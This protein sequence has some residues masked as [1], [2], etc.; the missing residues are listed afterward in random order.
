[1]VVCK[2]YA[3]YLSL[4]HLPVTTTPR[5]E[6]THFQNDSIRGVEQTEQGTEQTG[7]NELN[8]SA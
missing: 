4:R 1:M 2:T 3:T 5:T 8:L 7:V 6:H